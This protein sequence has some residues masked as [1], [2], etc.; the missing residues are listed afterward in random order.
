MIYSQAVPKFLKQWEGLRLSPYHDAGGKWTVGYGHLMDS[1][2]D[3]GMTITAAHA[4]MLLL[5][6]LD[7]IS[8]GV[9]KLTFGFG[10][11]QCEFDALVCFAFNV[12]LEALSVSTLYHL[13]KAGD[14]N[15]AADQFSRWDHCDGQVV[16]GL[17]SRR[18]AERQMFLGAA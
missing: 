1:E 12:G 14:H 10:L 4:D 7:R 18:L 3:T 17:L 16:P 13:L 9:D 5:F 15:G 11:R 6:D 2:D 8:T